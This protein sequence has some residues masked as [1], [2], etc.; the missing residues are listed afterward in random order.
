[1]EDN[2]KRILTNFNKYRYLLAELVRKDIKLKYRN[3]VLGLFWTMLEPLLTM[4]VLT[5]VFTSLMGRTTPHYPV[6]IL[7]GRLLYSYFS[8]GTKLALKS[9][10]RNSAMIRKVYVPKYIYPLSSTLSGFITFLISLIVLFAV[11]VVQN[12]KPTWHILEAIFPMFTLLLLTVGVG[13]IL[14]T[15]GVF[16]RDT[17][18][19]WGVILTLI[20]YASAI[21]YDPKTILKSSNAWILKYNPLFGIIQNFRNAVLGD[22][23]NTKYFAYSLIFSVVTLIIGVFMFYKKQDKFVLYI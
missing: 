16:F 21:F 17:E 8:N 1:M 13:F 7:C 5:I 6:Y 3:S 19:L 12:V 10:R 23:M 15:L 20:M 4:I 9:I 22:P 14:A 11:A 2:L 18:Y